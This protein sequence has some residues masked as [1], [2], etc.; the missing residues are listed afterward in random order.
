MASEP[1][2]LAGR[3]SWITTRL[4][5]A[6]VASGGLLGAAIEYAIRQ[7]FLVGMSVGIAAGSTLAVVASARL[8]QILHKPTTSPELRARLLRRV[9]LAAGASVTVYLISG[10]IGPTVHHLFPWDGFALLA[11]CGVCDWLSRRGRLVFA[12]T[13]F[14]ASYLLF[15]TFTALPSG[16]GSPLNALYL[17]SIILSGLVLGPGGFLGALAIVSFLTG[18]FALGEY[19]Q[20]WEVLYPTDD[21]TRLIQWLLIW[22]VLYAWVAWLTWLFARS[23]ERALQVS[24]SQTLTLARTLS[25]IAPDSSLDHVLRQTL[26]AIAEQ[27]GAAYA[28][29]WLHD[30]DTDRIMPHLAHRGGKVIAADEITDGTAS[31]TPARDLPIWQELHRQRRPIVIEDAANDP[32]L[33]FQAAVLAQNVQMI[34]CVPLLI[35]DRVPGFF[36]VNSVERRRYSPDELELAQ[37]LAQQV[38]LAMQLTR[39][40]EQNRQ[41][42]ILE[43]RNRMAREIHDTLAQGFTGIVVQLEAAEDVLGDSHGDVIQ[44]LSRAQALARE[45]LVEARRS[46]YALRPQSLQ[47]KPLP[48][49]LRDSVTAL[50]ADASLAIEWDLPDH[51]PALSSDLEADLLRLGQEAVTNVLKHAS[52]TQL[53]VALRAAPDSIELEVSDNGRGFDPSTARPRRDGGLGLVGMRERVAQHG[54]A[55]EITHRSPGTQVIARVPIPSA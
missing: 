48:T 37:A 49:A 6:A 32:R 23:L 46:V 8:R 24:R 53:R 4:W 11:V 51:W 9:I 3:R 15:A 20:L 41:A 29:L 26:S 50:T 17:P 25:A 10:A 19:Q 31:P 34:L 21:P 2:L 36:S 30:L 47:Y 22:W 1:S 45:S 5:L 38:T 40:A 27:L 39:L 18:V 52:A 16:L 42:A 7:S 44:H 54:G 13:L 33:R 55:L 43:E 14:L 35:G 28:I 12:A